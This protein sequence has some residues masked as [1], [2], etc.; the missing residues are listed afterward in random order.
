MVTIEIMLY[1]P[2]GYSQ[3]EMRWLQPPTAPP[4]LTSHQQYRDRLMAPGLF[5]TK[6]VNVE[7]SDLGES[8][9]HAVQA[10]VLVRLVQLVH[11]IHGG[12]AKAARPH[13]FYT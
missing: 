8:C 6:G 10:R 1:G 7:S 9:A 13:G 5:H 2:C 11:A 3:T 4:Q 12:I